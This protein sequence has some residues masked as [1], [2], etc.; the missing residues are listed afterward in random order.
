MRITP[1]N[2]YQT[3]NHNYKR[4]SENFKGM[5]ATADVVK[6]FKDAG[7]DVIPAG[8]REFKN[9]QLFKNEWE[10]AQPYVGDFELLGYLRPINEKAKII[11]PADIN[12]KSPEQL[13]QLAKDLE[14]LPEKLD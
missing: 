13:K 11:V 1:V 12:G 14:Y 8:R 7:I 6:V 5:V 2:N 9:L 3:Q 10:K 4:Q